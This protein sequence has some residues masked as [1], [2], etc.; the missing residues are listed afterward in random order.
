MK[1]ISLLVC[2]VFAS[3]TLFAGTAVQNKAVKTNFTISK[4]NAPQA[5]LVTE[6]K[7]GSF[8]LGKLRKATNAIETDT[9]YAWYQVPNQFVA[10]SLEEGFLYTDG[11]Y[12]YFSN[13]QIVTPFAQK[14]PFVNRYSI[15]TPAWEVSGAENV[16]GQQYIFV[17]A[18]DYG[19]EYILPTLSYDPDIL[20]LSDTTQIYF[21]PYTF[22]KRFS[23]NMGA[24]NSL[25]LAP[26]YLSVTQAG[27]YTEYPTVISS[28]LF[29]GWGWIWMGGSSLGAYSY[30]TKV[31]NPWI[32]PTQETINTTSPYTG[33]DTSVTVNNYTYFD[34]IIVT[35][36]S[37]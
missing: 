31:I 16:T 27:Y 3:V 6:R 30:G 35:I 4:A 19:G 21:G 36:E 5:E 25:Y 22:G 11:Q 10:G 8:N 32:A 29:D 24:D 12:F 14:V 34:S 33:N 1:K 9:M 26:Q 13:P 2:T 7:V 17:D 23:E 28:T 37:K 15:M 18:G 20:P